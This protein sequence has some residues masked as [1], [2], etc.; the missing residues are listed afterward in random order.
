MLKQYLKKNLGT[1]VFYLVVLLFVLYGFISVQR[2]RSNAIA[3]IDY[4]Y[5]APSTNVDHSI[6]ASYKKVAESE[7]LELYFDENKG[8]VQL[9][10]TDTGY[11]W[12]S[13]V[14]EEMYPIS[15]VNKQWKGYLQSIFTLSYNDINKRDVP[16]ATLYAGS[17]LDY[18]D[19]SY[20]DNGVHVKYG[21]TKVGLYVTLEYVLED[22]RFVVR[23]PYDGYEEHLQYCITTLEV[24][25]FFGS[26]GNEVDGYLLYPDG[27]GAI[28]TYDNVVNR[29]SKVKQGILRTYSNKKVGLNEFF[30]ENE[31]ERYVASMPVFGIKNNEDAILAAVTKGAEETG[32]MTYPSGIVVDLN[33]IGFE[34]YVRNVFD[35]DMFNVS[36]GTDTTANG[37][38]IQRVDEKII[39]TDREITYFFLS[40]EE[41]NYSKMADTY[42]NYLIEENLLT[43]KIEE[44]SEMPLALEFL[45]GVTESQMVLDKY[46]KMTSFDDLIN[47]LEKLKSKG[48]NTSKL[49]L[50]SW[51]KDGE[52]Y[53]NYWPVA[54]Q[55]GG[56]NGLKKLDDYIEKNKGI[57]AF[58]E[59]NFTF[60]VKEVGGFSATDDIVYSGVNIPITAGY[61]NTWYILNP[62]VTYNRAMDFVEKLDELKNIGVGYEYLGRIIY[63]D[64]NENM[65][66]KRSE[67]VAMWKKLFEDTKLRG[68]NT[69]T[70]GINQYTFRDVD[71]LYQVPL[72]S[73]GLA[74]T[75]ASVPFVQMVI[76]GMIPY[77]AKAGNLSYDLDIQKLIWIENGALPFFNLTFEDAVL[78]KETDYNSLF[79]S[80]YTKWEE[81]V[82]EVYKEFKEN[83]SS[84]YGKQMILHEIISDQVV[85]VG[86]EDNTLI[87]INYKN[88]DTY[89]DG[90]TIPAKDYI[91]TSREGE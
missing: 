78:L 4:S 59:N 45:M 13:I 33:R 1:I 38:E 16:P 42:R 69:A 25:P 40:G 84:L 35:V 82:E 68:H 24:L 3:K 32:I 20:I 27:S 41:A 80:T 28:T 14:D 64:Y 8:A 49:L 30:D 75:D 22:G 88:E 11:V 91:I 87:Y 9:K 48:I 15:S 60:A 90:L 46:I 51:I 65:P 86:Y 76:S 54:K 26:A 61:S 81:R 34:V 31:Y 58:L 85:K 37:K 6:A 2:A 55:I 71:Y 44:G 74:I 29:S 47:I 17:D 52:N 39:E 62:Q 43:S 70:E 77:S 72:S 36:T 7:N 73:Y 18:I 50:S 53:P 79:T 57:D 66:F 23:I 56:M 21:F 12:K 67:T 5:E 19:V 63:P 10:N 89:I 83:F